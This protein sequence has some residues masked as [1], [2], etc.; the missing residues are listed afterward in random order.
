MDNVIL[1]YVLPRSL[2]QP[3]SQ[4][5]IVASET[6]IVL[7]SSN[8]E[9]EIEMHSACLRPLRLDPG[10]PFFVERKPVAKREGCGTSVRSSTAFKYIHSH[11]LCL[12]YLPR[13]F[14]DPVNCSSAL[15]LLDV[16]RGSDEEERPD[17]QESLIFFSWWSL[18][19]PI[20]YAKS[21]QPPLPRRLRKLRDIVEWR[22]NERL[23]SAA[24]GNLSARLPVVLAIIIIYC[25]EHPKKYEMKQHSV[26]DV[27]NRTN[28]GI[29]II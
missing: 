14:V 19:L 10:N 5:G 16:L 28:L 4:P 11:V 26:L 6:T 2:L 22:V 24:I 23:T 7:A 20:R 9:N 27:Y 25:S 29:I 8:R 1:Y 15:I 3:A 21:S 18:R 13:N 17:L 12:P